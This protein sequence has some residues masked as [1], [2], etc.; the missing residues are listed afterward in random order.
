MLSGTFVQVWNGSLRTLPGSLFCCGSASVQ[1]VRE[2][3]VYSSLSSPE[4]EG[5]SLPGA[6]LPEVEG[7]VAQAL[8]W[9][10]RWCLTGL[11]AP[12]VHWLQAQPNTDLPR[13]CSL[14]GLDCYS[15]LF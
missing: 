14:C 8:P 6:A 9:W 15:G 11:R 1:V 13:N 12:Q 7:G 2:T 5:K 3:P 4:G 10:S